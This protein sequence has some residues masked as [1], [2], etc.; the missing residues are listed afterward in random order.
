VI[1]FEPAG[2]AVHTQ[3]DPMLARSRTLPRAL[4]W[5]GL[6]AA[7]AA[8]GFACGA[9]AKPHPA[10]PL[11]GAGTQL[12]DGSGMLARLSRKTP[13]ETGDDD[14]DD[15]AEDY[16]DEY[17]SD[18]YY[19]D[20]YGG[21]MYGF[22][23]GGLGGT[24]Y[25]NYQPPYNGYY[26]GTGSPFRG[27]YIASGVTGG[28]AIHGTVTWARPPAVPAE[29]ALAE[30]RGGCPARVAN[31][32]LAVDGSGRVA[33]AVV[34]L[35]DI[36]SGKTLP[37][38]SRTIQIG[39][40]VE[41][42]DCALRPQIQLMAPMNSTLRL[43]NSDDVRARFVATRGIDDSSREAAFDASVPRGGTRAVVSGA[44]GFLRVA[45]DSSGGLPA[46]IV[47]QGHPYFA[48]TDH[49]GAFRIDEIPA[50]TYELVVWHQPIATGQSADGAITYSD[51]I[52]QRS[53]ITIKAGTSQVVSVKLP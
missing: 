42:H 19:D 53:K 4:L 41:R 7:G 2:R 25:G 40:E 10:P 30:D 28:A 33:S 52:V 29:L 18:Y 45:E 17:T 31:T 48:I 16:Y 6:A 49:A 32:T 1:S 24:L 22:G 5:L 9:S 50:G 20:Y 37:Q 39:G 21:L 51:A 11:P 36:R 23:Y 35:S 3:P 14:D 34:F 12:D 8:A 44:D 38:F 46:W 15:A 43:S 26:N 27:D 13:E 47:V